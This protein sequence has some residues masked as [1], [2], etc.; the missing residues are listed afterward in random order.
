[1]H[2]F[3][4]AVERTRRY[5]THAFHEGRKALAHLDRGV[6]TAAHIYHHVAPILAPLATHHMGVERAQMAHDSVTGAFAKYGRVSE[7]ALQANRMVDALN[8]ATKKRT[9]EL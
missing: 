9:P 8:H 4:L 6:T 5:T 2:S 1:M 3:R 7:R